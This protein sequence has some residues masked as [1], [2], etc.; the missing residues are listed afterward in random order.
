MQTLTMADEMVFASVNH[1]SDGQEVARRAGMDDSPVEGCRSYV[2]FVWKNAEGITNTAR[3]P[4][5]GL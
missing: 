5:Q 3:T 2:C 1:P 4:W